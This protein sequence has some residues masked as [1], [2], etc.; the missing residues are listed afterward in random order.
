[1]DV[2][3][4]RRGVGIVVGFPDNTNAYARVMFK[5]SRKTTE[6]IHKRCLWQAP[7][8]VRTPDPES[9]GNTLGI[10]CYTFRAYRTRVPLSGTPGEGG[11]EE[12]RIRSTER[13]GRAHRLERISH[14]F[15]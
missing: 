14:S 5:L 11:L 10:R 8:A 1:M 15:T 13:R 6:N 4:P 9:G 12:R 7:T 3:D 2:R